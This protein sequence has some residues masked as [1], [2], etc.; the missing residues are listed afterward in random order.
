MDSYPL[1]ADVPQS[2]SF[3]ALP[4]ENSVV[5]KVSYEWGDVVGEF[6][7]TYVEDNEYSVSIPGDLIE[8]SGVYSVKW[9]AAFSGVVKHFSTSF[10]IEERY[11]LENEF[12]DRYPDLDTAEYHNEVFEKT[13]L[14]SRKIIDTFCG[15]NFQF[16]GNK[17]MSKEGN[18]RKSFYLGKRL[19]HLSEVTVTLD[20]NEE[21]YSEFTEVDWQSKYSLKSTSNFIKGAKVS[22]RG[23]WGWISVPSNIKEAT[24]L[25]IADILEDAKRDH[26]RYGIIRLE[27][28]TN[29]FEFSRNMLSESTGNLDV[30]ILIMDY[31]YW[32]P[33]WI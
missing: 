18:G 7:G 5:A 11:I 4:D 16:I 30:D 20:S 19:A 23:D 27:Q 6:A 26:H 22:V 3:P 29:R 10:S 15:Q 2:F 1:Y 31:V 13:E 17:T 9:T 14:I 28:D 12:F 8:A 21:D 33:D 25:L 32:V 24:A